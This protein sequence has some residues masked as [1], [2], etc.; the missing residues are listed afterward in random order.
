[1]HLSR[2]KKK[3]KKT[4]TG[5]IWYPCFL[6]TTVLKLFVLTTYFFESLLQKG[7]ISFVV[8]HEY[9]SA[10]YGTAASRSCALRTLNRFVPHTPRGKCLLT[11][12][13]PFPGQ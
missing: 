2:Q 8:P 7:S 6:Q 4:L 13:S 9:Y 11:T 3:K 10:G 5:L 1:M 12:C